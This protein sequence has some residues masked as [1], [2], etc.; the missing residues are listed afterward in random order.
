MSGFFGI[1]NQE[2]IVDAVQSFKEFQQHIDTPHHHGVETFIG[3]YFAVCQV[4]FKKPFERGAQEM[5]MIS[6]CGNFILAGHLRL[7]YRDELGDKLG[8]VQNELDKCSDA[9]LVLLAYKKWKKKAVFHLEGDWAFVMYDL[10]SRELLLARDQ[11][12]VSLLL[13]SQ[14]GGNILFS[15]YPNY[16]ESFF[17]QN[18]VINKRIFWL[19]CH[20]ENEHYKSETLD[21]RVKRVDHGHFLTVGKP[22]GL[23]VVQYFDLGT[24]KEIRYKFVEDCTN[25]FFFHISEAVR[26]RVKKKKS[27]GVFL[28]AGVDSST[29]AALAAIHLDNSGSSIHSYTHYPAFLDS[30]PPEKQ[31]RSDESKYVNILLS[32]YKKIIPRYLDF[33]EKD[34]LQVDV[35]AQS[36]LYPTINKNNFWIQ[37]IIDFAKADSVETMVTGQFGNYS[38]SWS[39][40]YFHVSQLLQFKIISTIRDLFLVADK[41]N[42]SLVYIARQLVFSPLIKYL[43][44]IIALIKTFFASTKDFV[45]NKKEIGIDYLQFIHLNFY[46]QKSSHLNPKKE[47]RRILKK[48]LADVNGKWYLNAALKSIQYCDPTSDGRLLNFSLGINEHYFF[49]KGLQKFLIKKAMQGLVPKEILQND[50]YFSQSA[51]IR[52]RIEC[53]CVAGKDSSR[54]LAY[55]NAQVKKLHGMDIMKLIRYEQVPAIADFKIIDIRY[56]FQLFS[57]YQFL[58]FRNEHNFEQTFFMNN[59]LETWS[60][61]TLV[62]LNANETA[63]LCVG[64]SATN[65]DAEVGSTCSE[66]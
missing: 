37:G 43:T 24:S 1:F 6:D 33:K 32:Q 17:H 16:F 7:D 9:S 50:K 66:S 58:L 26:A 27:I 48:Y 21:E 19:I 31:D 35:N 57:I 23:K 39:A 14:D 28:S 13:Y 54:T 41:N 30:I 34:V 22:A 29:V 15:T 5:S 44:S 2:G 47:R 38:I 61:P 60:K 3:Q 64:K 4:G 11:T 18:I 52:K 42:I 51:D 20:L 25:D 59:N 49:Y 40:P 63:T 45:F 53:S 12:G 55:F 62:E 8:L 56:F 10:H 46:L 65:D 36:I